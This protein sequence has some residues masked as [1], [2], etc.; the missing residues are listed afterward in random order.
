MPDFASHH[1]HLGQPGVRGDVP[2]DQV[3]PEVRSERAAPRADRLRGHLRPPHRRP[4]RRQEVRAALRRPRQIHGQAQDQELRPLG[5]HP[6]RGDNGNEIES[7][8][9]EDRHR[10]ASHK[11]WY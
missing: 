6:R 5:H 3:H 2:R 11:W 4:R 7:S 10:V 8:N 9:S 1:P